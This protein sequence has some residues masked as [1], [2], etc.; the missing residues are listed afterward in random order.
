MCVCIYMYI[1]THTQDGSE[2]FTGNL[3]KTKQNHADTKVSDS[4]ILATLVPWAPGKKLMKAMDSLLKIM[5]EHTY[6]DKSTFIFRAF[7]DLSQI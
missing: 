6:Y 2:T 7:S 3:F 4:Q 1:R 5:Y